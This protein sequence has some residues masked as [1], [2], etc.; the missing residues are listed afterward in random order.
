MFIKIINNIKGDVSVD[1]I[2]ELKNY[3]DGYGKLK[4][5]PS[6]NKYKL[7]ALEYL[8]SKFEKE[9]IYTERE[10][11]EVLNKYHSFNDCCLLRRELYNKKIIDRL[12]DGSKY[13]LQRWEL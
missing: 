6:K 7:L 12:K 3:L 11:N 10:I 4:V 2:L 5:Y 1:F 9:K 13:W 8:G